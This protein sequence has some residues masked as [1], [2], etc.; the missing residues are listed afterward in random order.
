MSITAVSF[1]SSA[2]AAYIAEVTDR[3]VN[4]AIDEHIV[5][6]PLI[7]LSAGRK[8]SRLAAAFI[9]FYFETDEIFTAALRKRV[10][11]TIAD[12]IIAAGKLERALALNISAID[13]GIDSIFHFTTTEAEASV[14]SVDFTKYLDIAISRADKVD[15]AIKSISTAED[16]MDGIPV[17]RGTRV[18][19]DIVLAS[20]E[21]GTDFARL[22]NSYSF[23]T[24]E[25]IEA[26]K[27]YVCIRPRRGR[28]RRIAD[29]H[30]DWKLKSTKIVRAAS[31]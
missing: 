30:P 1:V 23:L 9:S 19:I 2:E 11:S 7:Q 28:P 17:F 25:L 4:R 22:K 12:R 15:F 16:I 18:P 27:I 21:S 3:D 24:E 10:L 26:A 8:I 31:K 29:I 6:A 14:I 5:P 20:I 13:T